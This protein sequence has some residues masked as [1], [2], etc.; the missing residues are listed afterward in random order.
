MENTLQ[1]KII[2]FYQYAQPGLQ[3]GN[4][5]IKVDQSVDS[6]STQIPSRTY[7]RENRF[8]V[9]GPRFSLNPD[10]LVSMFPPPF[11]LGE[12][13]NVLPHVVLS[14][15]TIPWERPLG[16]KI[17]SNDPPWLGVIL[18]DEDDHLP[19]DEKD[20]PLPL[21]LQE[22]TL[23]DLLP[24]TQQTETGVKGLLPSDTYFPPFPLNKKTQSPELDFGESWSD[25][26]LVVDVPLILFNKIMPT[27]DDL[28]WLAHV[29]EIQLK[30]KSETYL[31]R[32]NTSSGD[33]DPVGQVAEV[34][35]N[36]FALPGKKSV[37]HLVCLENFGPV[38]PGASGQSNL[39]SGI[40]TVRLVSLTSWTFSAVSQ[41][42]TFAG[43]L[44]K[45]NKPGG[46]FTQ[47]TL[48]VPFTGNTTQRSDAIVA[49]AFNMGFTA[50]NHTTRLGDKTVSWFHGP[51]VPYNLQTFVPSPGNVA[52]EFTRYNPDSGMFNVSY[53]AAWQLGRLLGLQSS[54]YSTALYNWKRG[55]TQAVIR[56]VEQLFLNLSYSDMVAI[57]KQALSNYVEPPAADEP[58]PATE[59]Q[60]PLAPISMIKPNRLAAIRETL[61]NPAKAVSAVTSLFAKNGGPDV[62]SAV[63]KFLARLRL[64]YGLPF[65]YLVPDERMLPPESMR[66]FYMDSAWVDCLLE[67]ALSI[68]NSTASDAAMSRALAPFV[69]A[70]VNA[71]ARSIRRTVLKMP[72]LAD[73][74]IIPIANPTGFLLRS[75]VVTGWPGMEV[76]GYDAAGVKLDFLRLEQVGPGVLLCLF[77]GVVQKVEIHEHPE[78]LHFGVDEDVNNPSPAK[79]TKSFRYITA[80][81]DNQPGAPVPATIAPPLSIPTYT[82]QLV[83]SVLQINQLA[84]AIQA[85]LKQAN[86]YAGSFTSAE[87]A[88]EM[89]EGVQ[90]VTFKFAA[91]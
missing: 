27:T 59:T 6:K 30:N 42:Y 65:N 8:A 53:S 12:Y 10:E 16:S 90:Q 31:R 47:N 78:A 88:L 13:A 58:T 77:D 56:S 26:C 9:L 23:L 39:P 19:F 60:T 86:V 73:P 63:T 2:S 62:P 52:D 20:H 64:L 76:F 82:R 7:T 35:G 32:L 70:S 24:T 69:H 67:G 57:L 61:T 33:L 87:F 55:V 34:V 11:S 80:L 48:Q 22:K 74:P 18:F 85:A 79:F 44:L 84:S 37:A 68:G 83:S 46:A 51:F 49:N 25:K 1:K 72:L 21:T 41:E 3:D 89:I 5:S 17:I 40:T 75:Q 29:R 43:L 71:G 36:R 54:S 81:G 38:L 91:G 50:F 14:R 28:G 45:V 15:N 4:Y 66:F